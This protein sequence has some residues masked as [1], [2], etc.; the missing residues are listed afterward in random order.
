M[1]S[2]S[3]TAH[4]ELDFRIRLAGGRSTSQMSRLPSWAVSNEIAGGGVTEG[5]RC[6]RRIVTRR[7]VAQSTLQD[8]PQ[9]HGSGWR[10]EPSKG[11]ADVTGHEQQSNK[12]ALRQSL[13]RIFEVF[14]SLI[15]IYLSLTHIRVMP[16]WGSVL[17]GE[18]N[19]IK[20]FAV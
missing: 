14:L 4:C 20:Q 12:L 1:V 3:G 8:T 11:P 18:I 10:F 6:S 9:T 5:A 19:T 17:I 13:L 16:S 15:G 7:T 2:D